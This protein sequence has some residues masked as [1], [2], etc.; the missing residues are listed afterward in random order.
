MFSQVGL[1]LLLFLIGLEFDFSHLRSNGKKAL[2]I[3]LAGIVIPFTLGLLA[4]KML[5]PRVG[6]GIDERGF[7]LFVA[8]AIS[9]TALPILGRI[10]IEFNLH[11]TRLGVLTIT[12]A[13]IDDCSRLDS[14]G[15]GH[16][17]GEVEFPIAGS[18]GHDS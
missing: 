4:A 7:S 14:P 1:I 5:W 2:S 9:I 11:R 18:R 6:Q 17:D 15:G 13:A 12:A 10:L 8:T 3:S 16:R